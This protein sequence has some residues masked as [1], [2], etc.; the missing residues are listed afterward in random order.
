LVSTRRA[1]D[2][3]EIEVTDTGC[4]IA[5]EHRDRLFDPEFTTKPEGH[6]LGLGIV[7]DIIAQ[8]GGSLCLLRSKVGEGTSFCIRLPTSL[9]H[10]ESAQVEAPLHPEAS[11]TDDS[12][13]GVLNLPVRPRPARCAD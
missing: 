9:S 3:I 12:S 5:E 8:E 10:S 6:G 11:V 13:H 4:G 7:R 1:G 2:A